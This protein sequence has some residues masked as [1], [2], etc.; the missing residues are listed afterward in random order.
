MDQI[1]TMLHTKLLKKVSPRSQKSVDTHA[2]L[3]KVW[4]PFGKNITSFG[5]YIMYMLYATNIC[6]VLPILTYCAYYA[7]RMLRI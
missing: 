6:Y 3:Y 1:E 7:I 2:H 4:Y 5:T